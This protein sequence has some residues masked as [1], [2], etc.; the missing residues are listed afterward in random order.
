M[1]DIM[2]VAGS[3]VFFMVATIAVAV[4]IVSTVNVGTSVL[5]WLF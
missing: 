1:R 5:N 2:T 4:L 3:V